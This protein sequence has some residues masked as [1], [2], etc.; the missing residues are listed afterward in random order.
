MKK[1]F[2]VLICCLIVFLVTG[3]SVKK[4]KAAVE[5]IAAKFFDKIK[6]GD[7][8]SAMSLYSPKF[9][10]QTSKDD[11]KSILVNLQS[12]LGSLE[13]YELVSWNFKKQANT[14]GSGTYWALQYKVTYSKYPATESITIFRPVGGKFQILGH[15]INSTGLLKE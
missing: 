8:D 15:N 12:K 4:E 2:P 10:Q 5:A 1:C 13:R 3:C 7:F 9:F 11:W 6:S 14:S